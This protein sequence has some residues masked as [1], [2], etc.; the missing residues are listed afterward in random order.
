MSTTKA[1]TTRSATRPPATAPT[2]RRLTTLNLLGSSSSNCGG[3]GSNESGYIALGYFAIFLRRF[4]FSRTDWA[5]LRYWTLE[6]RASRTTTH[7]AGLGHFE[8]TGSVI[9]PFAFT[10]RSGKGRALSISTSILTL[11]ALTHWT[12][13]SDFSGG[14]ANTNTCF[15]YATPQWHRGRTR[16]HYYLRLFGIWSTTISTCPN[17]FCGCTRTNGGGWQGYT[18]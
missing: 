4:K 12:N 3:E 13:Q 2:S 6:P 9:G 11:E 15:S 10:E 14:A 5:G 16:P 1:T 17:C 18:N 7:Q 8:T